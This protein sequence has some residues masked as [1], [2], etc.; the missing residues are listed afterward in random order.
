MILIGII[1]AILLP[2]AV[3]QITTGIPIV[4]ATQYNTALGGIVA[5]IL[6]VLGYRRLHIFPGIAA[7][8]YIFISLT[9]TFA[10]LA[11]SFFMMR[12]DYSRLQFLS[13]YLLSLALYLY[14][15]QK[16]ALHRR[17]R[18]G[19]V[20]SA[21][22]LQL[23]TFD[24]VDWILLDPEDTADSIVV[25]A[26]VVDLRADH[27]DFWDTQI[28][29]YVLRAIPVYHFKQVVEQLSGRVEI[30]H[31]SENTLGALNPNDV[32]LKLKGAAD[33]LAATTLFLVLFPIMLITA[34]MVRLDSPGP[35]IF[36]Q[37][38]MGYRGKPFTIYKMRTM[39]VD[40]PVSAASDLQL[41]KNAMTQVGDPRITRLGHFLRRSR[42]D[43]LP[44][45]V[46]IIRGEM[47]L[48]GPRPEALPLSRWYE[49]EIPFYHYRHLIKPGVTGWAQINQ[50]HVTEVADVSEKLHLDFYY[51]KNL[52]FWLDVLI[53]VR[54]LRTMVSGHGAR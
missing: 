31:L 30:E 36:R 8:S 40:A 5:L 10:V 32:Y 47:S 11:V 26:I 33:I 1:V 34:L 9:T 4:Q 3:R 13:S 41:L 51:V 54:T 15:H 23:P 20:P 28:T 19:V 22:T 37:Q 25:D 14:I 42:L 27:D 7:G 2:M 35:A 16:I 18:V 17:L 50:G 48:I 6:G 29:R 52:S 49:R 24:K 21:A 43:E 46:N 39:R 12:I 53:S 44:Q 38:R 45:L